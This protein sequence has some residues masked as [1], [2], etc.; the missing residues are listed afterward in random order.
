[1]IRDVV[2]LPPARRAVL[3]IVLRNVIL[4]ILKAM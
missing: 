3:E 2:V 4:S 1:M